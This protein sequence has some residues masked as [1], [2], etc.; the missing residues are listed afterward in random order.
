MKDA[1]EEEVDSDEDQHVGDEL[2]SSPF[3]KL[4]L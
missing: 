3:V 2:L 1:I 4:I